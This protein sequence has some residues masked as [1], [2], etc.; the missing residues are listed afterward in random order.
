MKK[1]IFFLF[2]IFNNVISYSQESLFLIKKDTVFISYDSILANKN[3]IVDYKN[4]KDFNSKQKIGLS[5]IYKLLDK[6]LIEKSNAFNLEREVEFFKGNSIGASSNCDDCFG[7]W[8]VHQSLKNNYDLSNY[9]N[10]YN[11]KMFETYHLLKDSVTLKDSI[12]F[13]KSLYH[14]IKSHFSFSSLAL[15]KEEL[16]QKKVI[17]FDGSIESYEE[18]EKLGNE[19]HYFF[20]LKNKFE[21]TDFVFNKINGF[22]KRITIY[23]IFDEVFFVD[24]QTKYRY[25]KGPYF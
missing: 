23:Y 4:I 22:E 9:K 24:R 5:T 2:F 14:V 12:A 25:K 21:E 10:N 6:T 8:F 3:V 19:P 17:I 18:L 20:I 15:T 11:Y 16:S 7:L 13:D 1:V